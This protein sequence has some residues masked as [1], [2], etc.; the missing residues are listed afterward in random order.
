MKRGDVIL[1]RFPHASD[2]RGKKRP[3][4]VV[5][6]NAYARIVG[7]LVVAEVTKN[8]TMA[9]DPACLLID[10]STR[11][12]M[13]TGL[14]R[15]SVASCLVLMTVYADTVVQTLGTLSPAMQQKLDDCLK[16]ALA[17]P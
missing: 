8:L 13:A 2:L 17:L 16:M 4:V 10:T 11:E 7:T 12:G 1:V 15:D 14:V 6:S 5:Q 9:N 3:A